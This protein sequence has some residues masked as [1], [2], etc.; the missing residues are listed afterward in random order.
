M[1]ALRYLLLPISIIY[2]WVVWLRNRFFDWGIF[3]SEKGEIKTIVIGNLSVGGTGK[4]PHV[5]FIVRH[6]Q[7]QISL[8]ILS[9]GY[10]RTTKGFVLADGNATADK[11]GDEPMQIHHKFPTVPLAVCANRLEG[12]KELKK[13]FPQ[14][15]LVILDDAIQH[16]RLR[17]DKNILLTDYS[18]P[19]FR[20]LMLPTGTLRDNRR[21]NRRAQIIMVTKCPHDLSE[22]QRDAFIRNIHPNSHQEVVFSTYK[23]GTPVQFSGPPLLLKDGADIMGFSG[24]ANP[25]SFHSFIFRQ[26]SLKRFKIYPDHHRYSKRDLRNLHS[27]Y[28]TFAALLQGLVTTE[29]DATRLGS[30]LMTN[31][32]KQV[33]MF[34]IPVEVK[35]L[36]SPENFFEWLTKE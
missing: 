19:Y 27:A 2:S 21:E 13:L 20:D 7:E 5:E 31:E 11:L 22:S 29:K 32:F 35:L 28:I 36:H 15:R 1:T 30:L 17:G 4:T 16:R 18:N 14:T 26:Y 3:K 8:A 33:P 25:A 12:I 24:I 9:R 6:L 23:Y 34:F 10:G